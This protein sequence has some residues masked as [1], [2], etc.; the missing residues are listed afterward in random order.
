MNNPFDI[1]FFCEACITRLQAQCPHQH[2]STHGSQHYSE[3]VVWDDLMT[4]CDD[5]G[6]RLNA[7]NEVIPSVPDEN[8]YPF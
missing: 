2:I 6:A 8:Q 4:F 5:C 1:P 3:G 7:Q